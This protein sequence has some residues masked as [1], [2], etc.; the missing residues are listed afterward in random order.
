[1][2]DDKQPPKAPEKELWQLQPIERIESLEARMTAVEERLD[3]V[4]PRGGKEKEV[5]R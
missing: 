2:S 4:M 5:R 1:M 3:A